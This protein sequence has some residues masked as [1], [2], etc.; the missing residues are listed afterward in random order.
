MRSELSL[1]EV[2]L[3]LLCHGLSVEAQS[4]GGADAPATLADSVQ[5]R[6]PDER[7][8]EIA[9]GPHW[10]IQAPLATSPESRVRLLRSGDGFSLQH[11]E[12]AWPISVIPRPPFL[13]EATPAG[14]PRSAICLT[15]SNFLLIHPLHLH[16]EEAQRGVRITRPG[17]TE[18]APLSHDDV[19]NC[20]EAGLSAEEID[21]VALRW[22]KRVTTAETDLTMMPLLRA[23]RR[24]F[25]VVVTVE[26]APPLEVS[27]V[28]LLYAVGVDAISLPSLALTGSVSESPERPASLSETLE[29]LARASAV[30]PRGTVLSPLLIGLESPVDTLSSVTRLGQMGVRAV[31]DLGFLRDHWTSVRKVWTDDHLVRLWQHL[32]EELAHAKMAHPWTPHPQAQA[33]HVPPAAFRGEVIGDPLRPGFWQSRPGQTIVRNLIRLRRRLRVRSVDQSFESSEL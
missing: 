1:G 4:P 2:A 11:G 33:T 29:C 3:H 18:A 32:D 16:P 30:F 27:A 17:A 26:C 5:R 22:A 23:I 6:A 21:C 25:D 20:V 19:L 8:L 7:L 15:Y 31:F 14:T 24:N 12:D 10:R 13:D 28:D 9:L